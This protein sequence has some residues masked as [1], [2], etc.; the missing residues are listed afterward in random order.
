MGEWEM[1]HDSDCA[2]N[3]RGVPALLGPCD[4]RLKPELVAHNL[5]EY[6]KLPSLPLGDYAKEMLREAAH[7]VLTAADRKEV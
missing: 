3:N 7:V 2:T 5:N 6:A 1:R 4:C